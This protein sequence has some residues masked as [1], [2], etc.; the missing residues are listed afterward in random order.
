MKRKQIV[1]TAVLLMLS[2]VFAA[3]AA[4]GSKNNS[5]ENRYDAVDKENFMVE[6]NT[7]GYAAEIPGFEYVKD[8]KAKIIWTGTVSMETTNWEGTMEGLT[9]LFTAC[10]VQVVSSEERGG[11]SYEVSGVKRTSAR[12]ANYVVR[13]PSEK[14]QAF[15][16]G[17]GNVEGAVVSSN[18]SSADKTKQYNENELMLELLNT[19]YEDLKQLLASAKDLSEIL[20]VRDRMTEV[21]AE[22][23]QY[24]NANN[25]IDYDADYSR[26]SLSLREVVVYSDPEKADSWF[27]QVGKAFVQGLTGFIA[28]I[29]NVAVWLVGHLFYLILIAGIAVLMIVLIRKGL[30]KGRA[31]KAG[32]VSEK[33]EETALSEDTPPESRP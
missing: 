24:S 3:C 22:I 16:N 31:K 12:S 23:R 4:A 15:M 20:L 17:F 18:T 32:T 33:K 25:A 10:D 11:T 26:V 7:G 21:L 30:R 28:V 1:L 8:E 5:S 19:E 14:F 6:E 29:G 2:T 27:V 9:D 13:V